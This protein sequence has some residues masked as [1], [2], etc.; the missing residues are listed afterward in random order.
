MS[1]KL[2][3]SKHA[4]TDIRLYR[5]SGD[6]SSIKKLKTILEELLEHPEIGSGKPEQLTYGLTG[7]Y[8]RRINQK[9]RLIYSI[10]EENKT[11]SIISAKKHY[12]DK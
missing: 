2:E 7:L 8:S 11:V 3:F 12:Q 10:D 6:Q 5:K 9:D 4:L 1:Y